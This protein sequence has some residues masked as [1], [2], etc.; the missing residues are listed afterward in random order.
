MPWLMVAALFVVT[1]GVANPIAARFSEY[2]APFDGPPVSG[3]GNAAGLPALT[4]P[5]GFG[6]R[7][8][9]TSLQFAGRAGSEARLLAVAAAYQEATDWHRRRP[10]GL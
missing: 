8:L 10:P 7:G 9:P 4:V 1:F 5:N 6:E 2:F 3:A